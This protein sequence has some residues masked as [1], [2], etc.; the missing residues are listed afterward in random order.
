MGLVDGYLAD[1][2]A[3]RNA[4]GDADVGTANINVE[5]IGSGCDGHPT[6]ATHE[7]MADNLVGE[8]QTRLGW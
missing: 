4:A 3:Q 6:I 5:W 1:A 7:G 2:V 8:L